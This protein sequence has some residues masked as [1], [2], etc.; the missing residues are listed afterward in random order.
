VIG[1]TWTVWGAL[2]TDARWGAERAHE[3]IPVTYVPAAQHVF[4]PGVVWRGIGSAGY[5][6]G[7][8]ARII[9]V[10]PIGPAAFIEAF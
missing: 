7:V 5:F 6:I 10:I 4:L 3:A 8:N 1:R 9:P 2:L